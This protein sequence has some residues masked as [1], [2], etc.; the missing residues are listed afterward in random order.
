MGIFLGRFIVEFI[1]MY[2]LKKPWQRI[3]Y[4]L[5][6]LLPLFVL[7]MQGYIWDEVERAALIIMLST[8]WY[9]TWKAF[10]DEK[11]NNMVKG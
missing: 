11:E 6:L 5:T 7:R 3:L 8:A 9:R 2:G 1:Q 4:S 10:A